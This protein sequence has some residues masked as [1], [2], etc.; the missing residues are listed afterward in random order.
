MRDSPVSQGLPQRRH[1]ERPLEARPPAHLV[2]LLGHHC[3]PRDVQ[4]RHAS[5]QQRRVLG[6]ETES[7]QGARS[8]QWKRRPPWHPATRRH[9]V[10]VPSR[11]QCGPQSAAV[12][13]T[14]WRPEG[15]GTRAGVSCNAFNTRCCGP[16]AH[17][18]QR[19]PGG[20]GRP[21][22]SPGPSRC[23]C[24]PFLG[25]CARHSLLLPLHEASGGRGRSCRR[26]RGGDSLRSREDTDST[27]G[28]G[29]AD[30]A[31][32]GLRVRWGWGHLHPASSGSAGPSW[33][34]GRW[35]LSWCW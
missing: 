27:V 22:C 28:P 25:P 2:S 33:R 8:S 31:A 6:T 29:A 7:A 12:Q 18:A 11:H 10:M 5:V 17:R 13:R 9:R 4:E 24:W 34:H 3:A 16:S 1:H 14:P 26:Q 32:P 35:R 20:S 23:L 21:A 15:Q 30:G 19:G